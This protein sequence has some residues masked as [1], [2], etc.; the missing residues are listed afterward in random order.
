VPNT[1]LNTMC[2]KKKKIYVSGVSASDSPGLTDEPFK[3]SSREW[4][5]DDLIGASCRNLKGKGVTSGGLKGVHV[6]SQGQRI[7]ATVSFDY[8]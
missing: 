5:L 7:Q 1:Q 8:P 4:S 6:R 2:E 3:P